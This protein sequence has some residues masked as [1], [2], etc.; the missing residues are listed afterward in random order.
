MDYDIS[1]RD[2]HSYFQKNLNG[3]FELSPECKKLISKCSDF[4]FVCDKLKK[5]AS[6]TQRQRLRRKYSISRTRKKNHKTS[7]T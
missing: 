6:D 4:D 2:S 3:T 5:Q 7:V 1:Q